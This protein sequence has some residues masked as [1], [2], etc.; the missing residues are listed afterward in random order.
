MA[1]LTIRNVPAKTVTS[2]K[3]TARRSHRSMEQVVRDILDEHVADRQSV[4]AQIETAWAKQSRRPT[5]AEVD[6]WIAAGR[7]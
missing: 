3:A 5:A 1:T 6:D 4:L 2:L 7:P